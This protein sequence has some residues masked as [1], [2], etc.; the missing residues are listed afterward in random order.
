MI[1]FIGVSKIYPNQY[2][3]LENIN[4]E[5][6]E[7]EFLFMIGPS[8]S[9]KTTIIRHIIREEQPTEG[10][11]YFDD[12][13]IT[14][15]KRKNV[16]ELRRKIGVVFQD[17]KLIHDKNAYENIAFAMEAAGKSPKDIEE[18]VPYVLDIVGL[19]HRADAF[20]AQLSGGEKQRVAIARAI[21]NNP[22]LLIA[23]EPTGN[24]DPDAAWDIVQILT[25][26][27]NWGTTVIMA[28]H[29]SEIV[30]ALGKRVVVIQNGRIIQ[31]VLKGTYRNAELA[32]EKEKRKTEKELK[33]QEKEKEREKKKEKQGSK[34]ELNSEGVQETKEKEMKETD[35]KEKG[36][37]KSEDKK[38]EKPKSIKKIGGKQNNQKELDQPPVTLTSRRKAKDVIN[39]SFEALVTASFSPR[40]KKKEITDNSDLKEIINNPKML[41]I[42]KAYG[43][44]DLKSLKEKG[45]KEVSKIDEFSAKDLK[46]LKNIIN[47]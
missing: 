19:L 3:A 15:Y 32:I 4:L 12:D 1:Q 37:K 20:P 10:R 2:K 13:E 8:G 29:G 39:D 43:Y 14:R 47:T 36:T 28:T 45:Y 46:T 5:I 11:I 23:D 30:D 26:I 25:K 16:Y 41:S 38:E 44:K 24:L 9:G 42:L 7:G 17:Y 33:K 22:K 35:S 21:S 31:D 18:T 40:K 6:T 27:N 34:N